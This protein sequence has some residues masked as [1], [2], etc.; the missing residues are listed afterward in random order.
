MR[1]R[2]PARVIA[3]TS[4][5]ITMSF[6]LHFVVGNKLAA[7]GRAMVRAGFCV[8]MDVTTHAL[9]SVQKRAKGTV[10]IF[11]QE[12]VKDLVLEMY[13]SNLNIVFS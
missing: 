2:D 9:K 13:Y 11:A 4:L 10:V 6:V 1:H 5:L 12:L 7:V 8:Q 3:A